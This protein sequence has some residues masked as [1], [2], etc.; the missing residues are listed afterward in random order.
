MS[1]EASMAG[2]YAGRANEYERI[3]Q[4]PERQADLQR[5][6][7]FVGDTFAGKDVLEV[8]CGTGYW[9]EILARCAASVVATD[10][11]DEVLAIARAKD[12]G[13]GTLDVGRKVT[14]RKEDAYAPSPALPPTPSSSPASRQFNAGLS[15]FWWSHIRK[16]RLRE[17]LRGFHRVLSP[18]ARV[19]FMDNAYVE[20]SSTPVSRTDE[21]GDTYQIRRLDDGSVHEVLKNFPSEPELRAVVEGLASDVRVEF[22]EYY[23]ILS[24]QS[25]RE[26]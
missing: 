10:I 22:L 2:Y 15:A 5:L 16:S 14:F 8:A 23:W 13:R 3:Y 21:Q 12:M 6:H 17:F 4:K 18:G 1:I 20:G 11:N 19:V 7:R 25:K 24:Y 9:T 26:A